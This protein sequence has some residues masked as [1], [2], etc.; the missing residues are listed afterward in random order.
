[1]KLLIKD[2][3]NLLNNEI[4]EIVYLIYKIFPPK[5]K[6]ITINQSLINYKNNKILTF[7]KILLAYQINDL[8]GHAEIFNRDIIIDSKIIQI[9]AL[10]HVCVRPEFRGKNIG[11]NLVKNAFKFIDKNNFECSLF[12]TKTPKFYEKINCK[13]INNI[14][15]NSKNTDDINKNPWWGPYIMIYPK[16]YEIGKSVIDLNGDGY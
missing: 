10:K 9:L 4:K 15:I 5:D 1:M 7:N 8:I 3:K 13:I 6:N 14:F 2:K 11:L 16:N 12:Q